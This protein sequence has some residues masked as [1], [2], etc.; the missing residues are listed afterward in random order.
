MVDVG[1]V[2]TVMTGNGDGFGGG[3]AIW[4]IV[5][6]A[7][8]GGGFGRGHGECGR[9]ATDN[10]ELNARFNS[11]E[12]QIANVND[13]A[14]IRETYKES[15]DTNMNVTQQGMNVTREVLESKFDNALIAKDAQLA[16]QACCCETN[17]NILRSTNEVQRQIA[18]CYMVA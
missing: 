16:A 10:A 5:L 18:D 7:L 11:L 13:L 8:L 17:N 1:G 2:P 12:G 3:G 6:I 9:E 4:A 14:A 15:C